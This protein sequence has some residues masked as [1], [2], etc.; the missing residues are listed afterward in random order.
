M[1][2][3]AGRHCEGVCAPHS[4]LLLTSG[5]QPLSIVNRGP[6]TCTP[7]RLQAPGGRVSW[8]S[9]YKTRGPRGTHRNYILVVVSSITTKTTH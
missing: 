6:F 5:S 7:R 4:D 3:E 9:G 8:G 1:G 2:I